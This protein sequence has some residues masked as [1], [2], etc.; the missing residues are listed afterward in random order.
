MLRSVQ[1]DG[2]RPQL[3]PETGQAL[4]EVGGNAANQ[5]IENVHAF[6]TR[7]WSTIHLFEGKVLKNGAPACRK[8]KVLNNTFGPAGEPDGTWAD[9]I[10]MACGISLVANNVIRDATDGAIVVFGAPGTTVR[11]NTIIAATRQLLGGINMVDY[12]PVS[13]NY[14]D[15]VV[16]GNTID[17]QGAFIKVGIGMGLG[18]WTC[19]TDVNYGGTV[20]NNTLEGDHFGYG[21]V[22]N[23]VKDWTVT[24]SKDLSV[25][26]G[27]PASAC[28]TTPSVPTGFEDENVTS[29]TLQPEF[30]PASLDGVLNVSESPS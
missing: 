24:G 10:S 15:T 23:G 4:I 8:A 28:G 18:V 9:G 6:D 26:D 3:G 1:V 29:S 19:S 12:A 11:N 13:G 21:F 20:T 7:S 27:V 5:T 25:H 14:T 30:Q 16:T 2:N 17:A 22:A